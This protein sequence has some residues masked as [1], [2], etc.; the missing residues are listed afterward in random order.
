MQVNTF[1]FIV[2]IIVDMQGN[3]IFVFLEVVSI[4]LIFRNPYRIKALYVFISEV[5]IKMNVESPHCNMRK[6][7][8]IFG[9]VYMIKVI[10]EI[11]WFK[12]TPG[13]GILHIPYQGFQM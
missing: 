5:T 9:V 12:G 13:F 6:G 10:W 11:G 2:H 8:C 1:A 3:K 4:L 7:S